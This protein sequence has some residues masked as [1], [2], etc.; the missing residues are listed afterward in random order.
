[1]SQK[2]LPAIWD[3]EPHTRAK[4]EI[5]RRYLK[6]WFPILASQIRAQR[7]LYVDGFAG[8]GE[9]SKG[10]PGSPLIAIQTARDHDR[11]FAAEIHMAFIEKDSERWKHLCALVTPHTESLRARKNVRLLDPEQ[12]DCEEKLN[13]LLARH[14]KQS[15]TFGPALIFLDQFG[16]S[17][18]S[19]ELIANI[20]GRPS[21]EV[22]TYLNADGIRRFIGDQGKHAALTRAYGT[23]KWQNIV[24][25][26]SKDEIPVELG[27]LYRDQLKAAGN[28]KY[29]R[30]FSMHG[31]GGKL[32]YWLFFCTNNIRGLE[33]MKKA[34][35]GVD[36]S[37]GEFSFSDSNNENQIIFFSKYDESWL[38][39]RLLEQFGR[40]E[41]TVAEVHAFVLENTP[42]TS[43]RALLGKME[44]ENALQV[45]APAPNRRRGTFSDEAMR[46]R[47]Q[48]L[49]F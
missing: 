48:K 33:E 40:T 10:E 15:K 13:E 23:E 32:L 1:M 38:R 2:K 20:M 12:G 3:M 24:R 36:D 19:M 37:G 44:R 46:L 39:D 21:C 30:H 31:E 26:H 9:Y 25:R 28:S 45:V 41:P 11:S 5:L 18:V 7:V 42:A 6:A 17:D 22:F 49:L 27:R 34:M 43:F 29:V 4:H 8:P 35:V 16:Y 14:D 47:F